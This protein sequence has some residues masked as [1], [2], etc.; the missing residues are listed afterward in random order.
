MNKPVLLLDI[1]DESL[2]QNSQFLQIILELFSSGSG[3][4]LLNQSYVPRNDLKPIMHFSK[5]IAIREANVYF[6]RLLT[7]PLTQ[8]KWDK[9]RTFP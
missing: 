7:L 9:G 3:Y 1:E 2:L 6:F 8:K 5:F 4:S